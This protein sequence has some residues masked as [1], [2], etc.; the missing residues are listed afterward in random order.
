MT[1][2]RNPGSALAAKRWEQA[3]AEERKAV[4]QLRAKP[5]PCPKCGLTQPTARQAR[6][7]CSGQRKRAI[8]V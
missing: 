7:H 2:A 3:S 8:V 1:R 5:T 6:T 4:G